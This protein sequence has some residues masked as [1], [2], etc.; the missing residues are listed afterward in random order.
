MGELIERWFAETIRYDQRPIQPAWHFPVH[1]AICF[2]STAL[3]LGKR[4]RAYFVLPIILYNTLLRITYTTGAQKDDYFNAMM[5]LIFTLTYTD[6]LVVSSLIQNEG[7]RYI[8]PERTQDPS[9]P[10]P[11]PHEGKALSD[12][13]TFRERLVWAARLFTNW[14]GI[15]WNWQI[16]KLPTNPDLG[17]SRRQ[18]IARHLRRLVKYFI[19]HAI[20]LCI[21]TFSRTVITDPYRNSD[22]GTADKSSQIQTLALSVI[23][24]WTAQVWT[25]D[26]SKIMHHTFA[27]VTIALNLCSPADWPPLW[28]NLSDCWSV[29]QVWGKAYHQFFC[30]TFELY[31]NVFASNILGLRK[32]SFTS[33]YT[34]LYTVFFVSTCIHWWFSFCGAADEQG[35]FR[36]FMGQAIAISAEDFVQW[37][38]RGVA[39]GKRGDELNKIERL[40]GY[41]W[42]FCW[43]TYSMP[44]QPFF[45]MGTIEPFPIEWD[46]RV[47]GRRLALAW[48]NRA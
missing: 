21:L 14:R 18:A 25:M 3:P 4:V 48:M 1:L 42:T 10:K 9:K 17:V 43:F 13:A 2:L 44:I 30:R 16:N 47:L 32:G 35:N 12:C 36:Y 22:N 26:T 39:G 23:I 15:G 29:R 8:D 45:D 20:L 5:F 28:G 38:W 31:S 46:T 27:T 41:V 34:K 33:K 37:C 19:R 7:A 24:I 6:H 11:S 40:V